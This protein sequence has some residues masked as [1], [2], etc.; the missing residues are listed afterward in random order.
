MMSHT[1][2]VYSNINSYGNAADNVNCVWLAHFTTKNSVNCEG[3]L[4][5]LSYMQYAAVSENIDSCWDAADN[6]VF[7]SQVFILI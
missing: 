1:C 7:S 2:A 5:E 6:L 4:C 3:Y